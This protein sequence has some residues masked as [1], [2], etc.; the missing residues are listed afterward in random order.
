MIAVGERQAQPR[1]QRRPTVDFPTPISPTKA[2]VR[3]EDSGKESGEASEGMVR[4]PSTPDAAPLHTQ[5][6]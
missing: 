4:T 1:R 6:R 2:M 3:T 5:K